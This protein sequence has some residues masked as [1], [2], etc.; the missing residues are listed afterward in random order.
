MAKFKFKY[1]PIKRVKEQLEK[2]VQKEIAELND[3]IENNKIKI[4]GIENEM[5]LKKLKFKKG[6]KASELQ[7]QKN[8]EIYMTGLIESIKIKISEL[9]KQKNIKL[10]E[11]I[12]KTKEKKMF[13]KLEEKHFE[14]FN[15]EENKIEA[16][17]IDEVASQSFTR[18]K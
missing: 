18:G 4:S 12:E 17:R 14:K 7:F 10:L 8:Y 1:D 6:A 16:T 13:I 2:K 9:V 11:L 3:R 5:N 15:K